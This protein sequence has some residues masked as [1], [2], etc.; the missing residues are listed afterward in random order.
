MMAKLSRKPQQIT[1]QT[2]H[3]LYIDQL[4]EIFNY[5]RR[6]KKTLKY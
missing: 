1:D 4:E 2:N 6:E 5:S 3:K